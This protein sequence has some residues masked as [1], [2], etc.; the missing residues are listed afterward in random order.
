MTQEGK[1]RPPRIPKTPE[2]VAELV[3]L[4][5]LREHRNLETFKKTVFYKIFNVFSIGC[6]F[7]Y[8]ELII[9][10]LGPCHY[11]THYSRN[12]KVDFGEEMIGSDR[13]VSSVKLIGVEGREYEFRVNEFI[14]VPPKFGPF[15]VG[16]DFIL[17][18]E[19]K[20]CV[21]TSRNTYRIQRASP[22]L[23]LSFFVGIFSCIFFSY[24]LN[25]NPHSL[26]AIAVMNAITLFFFLLL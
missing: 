5:R 21:S 10:F 3:F 26:R 23:F 16:K 22:M 13:I 1:K 24:N 19:I 7:I 14:D 18:K 8:C 20:G 25:Q 9:C 15:E 17:Q 2:E 11:Q 4:K 12:I 6:F